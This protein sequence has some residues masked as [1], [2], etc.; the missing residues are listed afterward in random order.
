MTTRTGDALAAYVADALAAAAAL[1]GDGPAVRLRVGRRVLAVSFDRDRGLRAFAAAW[2]P[3]LVADDGAPADATLHV[4]AAADSGAPPAPP[5]GQGAY[6]PR[7]EVDGFGDE[8]HEVAFQI[9][10]GTLSL[11]DAP[12]S[13]GL[14]WTRSV[15]A[16]PVWERVMPLRA[17]LRWALRGFGLSLAHGAVAGDARGGLLLAGPGGAGKSTTVLAAA[18]RGLTTLA[19]DYVAIDPDGPLAHP[20]TAFAKATPGT[21]ALLPELGD[22][23]ASLPPT[24]EGKVA[25]ALDEGPLRAGAE[26]PL[27]AIVVL[28]VGEATGRPQPIG[29][30][31]A[32]AALA[33]TTLFQLPGSRPADHRLLAAIVHALPAFRLTVGPDPDAVAG[34]LADLLHAVS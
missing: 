22:R 33:P 16:I 21:L 27:R 18:R 7:D 13:R 4:L 30:S 10:T 29:K 3:L 25:V 34:A 19:D 5:W 1:T 11:W 32:M 17:P 20:L 26:M 6:R 24:P 8:R 12:S 28:G 14:W 23:L 31:A 15:E 2:R 9:E